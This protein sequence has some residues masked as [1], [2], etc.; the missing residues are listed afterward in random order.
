M[1]LWIFCPC[2]PPSRQCVDHTCPADLLPV[3][4]LA[5]N[6]GAVWR[7]VGTGSGCPGKEA[8]CHVN[9]IQSGGYREHRHQREE[10]IDRG[11][12]QHD[13]YENDHSITWKKWLLA[14]FSRQ[15]D[16]VRPLHIPSTDEIWVA[17]SPGLGIRIDLMYCRSESSIFG[18][19]SRSLV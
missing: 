1:S 8:P 11:G 12:I 6:C 17:S 9:L 19:G 5:Y 15:G 3:F 4:C 10:K 7:T 14:T 2:L 13:F 16:T 18:F